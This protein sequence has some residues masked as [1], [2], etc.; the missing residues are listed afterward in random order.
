ML[1]RTILELSSVQETSV[2]IRAPHLGPSPARDSPGLPMLSAYLLLSTGNRI[3][4][5]IHS[6]HKVLVGILNK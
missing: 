1:S 4:S 6:Q 3:I 2:P 5:G